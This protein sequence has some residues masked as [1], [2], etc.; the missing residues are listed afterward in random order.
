MIPDEG[1]MCKFIFG[2]GEITLERSLEENCVSRLIGGAI[3]RKNKP[4]PHFNILKLHSIITIGKVLSL[5]N[6]NGGCMTQAI[7]SQKKLF[8][9]FLR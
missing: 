2:S 5:K 4:Y 1:Q 7:T 3:S 6:Y 9:Y 8:S